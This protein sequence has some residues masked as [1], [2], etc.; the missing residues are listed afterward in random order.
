VL[1]D[2]RIQALAYAVAAALLMF[3][4]QAVLDTCLATDVIDLDGY[5]IG[6]VSR[7]VTLIAVS[8]LL[9]RRYLDRRSRAEHRMERIVDAS[10]GLC[11]LVD[12]DG[13]IS[14]ANAA[15]LRKLS[16]S[17]PARMNLPLETVLAPYL[18]PMHG[19]A[20]LPL[21][22]ENAIDVVLK[23]R[24]GVVRTSGIQI[25][26]LDETDKHVGWIVTG[27]D[28]ADSQQTRSD[29]VLKS[30]AL[31]TATDG[32]VIADL[33]MPDLPLIY[34]NRAFRDITGY[35]ADEVLGR[36]LRF[37]Q[38]NDRMQPEIGVMRERIAKR[39]PVTV[40]LRNYR[41]DGTMFWN[42]IRLSPVCEAATGEA[43][44]G[45][46]A[47]SPTHYICVLRDVTE[48][49]QNAR[50]LA[51]LAY[52]DPATGLYNRTRF[53]VA[54]SG[55]LT[56]MSGVMLLVTL[57]V[58]RFND[59]VSC[60][61][62]TAGDV[63]L[64]GIAERLRSLPDVALA[65]RLGDNA[66]GIAIELADEAEAGRVVERARAMLREPFRLQDGDVELL[67]Y[68]GMAIGRRNMTSTTL[69]HQAMV[70]L[71]QSRQTRAGTPRIFDATAGEEIRRRVGLS[72]DL[73]QA[74]DR[75]DFTLHLQPTVSLD[76]NSWVGG[77]ALA[78]WRH[79]VFGLQS[80]DLFLSIS[81]QTGQILEIDAWALRTTARIVKRLNQGSATPFV[82]SVN[83]SSMRL[84]H[85]DLVPMLNEILQQTGADPTTLK[86]EITERALA[87]D[88][89]E[90][91]GNL[92]RLR[93]LGFGIVIDDFGAGPS[94]LA[95]LHKLPVTE[96][97]I[98]RRF[99][100]GC[101]SSAYH[102]AL[103]EG[104]VAIGRTLSIEVTATGVENEM[105]KRVLDRLG[106]RQA[107]G[108]LFGAPI[109]AA[110]FAALAGGHA[111]SI[112]T[113]GPMTKRPGL[114]NHTL[115][116]H[117][118]DKLTL[119]RPSLDKPGVRTALPPPPDWL[120]STASTLQAPLEG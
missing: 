26:K 113:N 82:L 21:Q 107:Q 28:D 120:G 54:L 17:Y 108:F 103:I 42:E 6:M 73:H 92:S 87:N 1:A 41:R 61:G 98:D 31:D 119:D 13:N 48:L 12:K 9:M 88:S 65:G 86:L 59:I 39:Q 89:L 60:F 111:G 32:I 49:R 80:P 118:L 7:T 36:N 105:Q 91:V 43:R 76:D 3:C 102:Q 51:Q 117:P 67:F 5:R 75:G 22:G 116:N 16:P 27:A 56:R 71:N 29:H 106:I 37:L 114:D 53:A 72:R 104:F 45:E 96:I 94:C 30:Q 14:Y 77:E 20:L 115:D 52:F 81:E 33:R 62:E 55:L 64:A 44:A 63:L 58:M 97:K 38:G 57:D 78:R 109:D 10:S 90:A 101:E 66:F 83:L 2:S 70:A 74:I 8:A 15:F 69:L 85:H 47:G 112:T 79:P 24:D 100:H 34:V 84:Q 68:V 93:S 40:T 95:Q 35:T 23:G 50:E 11:A 25:R 110:E 99:I 4:T 18:I 46:M 19:S